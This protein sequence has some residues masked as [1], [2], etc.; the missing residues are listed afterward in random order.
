VTFSSGIHRCLGASLARL[1]LRIALEEWLR[2]MP[3]FEV[4]DPQAVEWTPGNTRGPEAVHCRV[5]A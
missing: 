5:T 3:Q 4:V 1:E 2:V